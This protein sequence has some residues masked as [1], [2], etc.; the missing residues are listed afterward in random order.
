MRSVQPTATTATYKNIDVT[1]VKWD[2][3]TEGANYSYSDGHARYQKLEQT[4]NSSRY[5]YGEKWY[6]TPI[7]VEGKVCP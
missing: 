7:P 1:R 2:R 3:H 6:P 4:L 5:Q